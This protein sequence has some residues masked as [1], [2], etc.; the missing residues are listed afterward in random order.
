MVIRLFR[1]RI[2][3]DKD[4]LKVS[5]T[6]LYHDV[7]GYRDRC[8]VSIH[9]VRVSRPLEDDVNF[10]APLAN[11]DGANRMRV[12]SYVASVSVQNMVRGCFVLRPQ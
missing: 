10:A 12:E 6:P 4:L 7:E 5:H 9:F 8:D 3:R 11:R 2:G 1:R